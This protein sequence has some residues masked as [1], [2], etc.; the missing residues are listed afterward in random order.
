[1]VLLQTIIASAKSTDDLVK[2]SVCMLIHD[3]LTFYILDQTLDAEGILVYCLK[4][5]EIRNIIDGIFM[6]VADDDLFF[7]I[8]DLPPDVH[9]FYIE[10]FVHQIFLTNTNYNT[11]KIPEHHL[12]TLSL[13]FFEF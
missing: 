3:D 12:R 10:S 6:P 7:N 4:T 8:S 13:Y 11:G 1:M 2:I 5:I 9:Q